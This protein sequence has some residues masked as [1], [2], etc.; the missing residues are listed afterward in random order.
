MSEVRTHQ[1]HKLP[2]RQMTVVLRE[3]VCPE[4]KGQDIGQVGTEP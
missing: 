1:K 2:K 3:H 4:G